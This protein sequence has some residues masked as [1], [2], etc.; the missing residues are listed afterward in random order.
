MINLVYGPAGCG[1]STYI[2]NRVIDD[3]R[4]RKK[5]FLIVPDQNIL[6]AEKAIVDSAFDVSVID[7]EVLSFRRLA[8]HVFRSLGG[9]SFNDIDEG[10]RLLIM[11][12]VLCETAPFLKTYNRIDEKNTSFAELM[13]STVNELKQFSITPAMLDNASVRL[14]ES[15]PTFSDKLHDISFIYGAYQAFLS[16]EYNDPADELTRLSETLDGS[17]FFKG[18]NVYFD[19]FDNYTPQQ[20]EVIHKIL[21]QA[22]NVTFSLCY[23]PDDTTGI[24]ATTQRSLRNLK[25]VADKLSLDIKE[26]HLKESK[27]SR[28]E[29]IEY[30]S[31]NLWRHEVPSEMYLGDRSHVDTIVC[32][33]SFEE[34]EAIVCDILKKV[35]NGVRY[36]DIL[37][38]ARDISAYEGIIDSEFENNGIPFFMSKRTDVTSKPIFK[39]ILAALAI[40]NKGWQFNDVISYVKTG[41]TGISRDECDILENY[42]SSW[43][44]KGSRWYDGI[45]WNMNPDGFS[46]KISDSGREMIVQAN[47]IRNKIV[48]PLMKFF[49]CIG[50]TTVL[51]VTRGLYDLLNDLKIREQIEE[52]AAKCRTEKRFVEEKEYV[53]LWNMLMNALDSAVEYAGEM[54]V[55]GDLYAVILGIILSKT[56]I[57]TIP[58]SVDQVMLGSASTLRTGSV[59][60]VYLLGVNEGIFPR[61]ADENCIFS[62]NEKN[63]LKTFDVE[64]SPGSDEQNCDELFWFYKAISC[65]QKGLILTYSDSDL[66]GSAKNLS[67]AGSRVNY[68]LNNKPIIRYSELSPEERLE[69]KSIALKLLALNRNN[70]LGLGLKKY[71]TKDESIKNIVEAFETP[72]DAVDSNINEDLAR[73]IYKGDIST[74]QSRIDTYVK[75]SFDYHCRYVL[76][77]QEKKSAVFRSNDIGNF[78]HAVL[79]R[80]MSRIATEDGIDTNIEDCEINRIVDEIINDYVRSV[81]VGLSENSPRF[82]QLVK[83]LK[84]TTLLL[85]RNLLAEFRQ[86]DFVPKFFEL[87]I[88]Y[89]NEEGVEPY[90]IPLSDGS[91]LYMR[92]VIDR[93][94]TYKKGK[95]VY[96]RIVDYK[97]GTKTFSPDDIE[98]GLNLQM[99]LYLFAIWNTKRDT[100]KEKIKCEGDIIPAGILYFAA[101]APEVNITNE[102][103]L[104]STYSIAEQKISRVGMLINDIEVLRAMDKELDHKYIPVKLYKNGNLSNTDYLK[105]VE[106][107]GELSRKIDDILSKIADEMKKGLVKAVPLEMKKSNDSPCTYCKM[108]PI[109]RRVTRGDND[110]F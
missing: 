94:D 95:D 84:R 42:A 34:C 45:D 66:R 82:I 50:G 109:C 58:A 36:K 33:D 105:T 49:D 12:R 64:L 30:V 101:K 55:N 19:S 18:C 5:S 1:K 24:F 77:L 67:V 103:E 15:N 99:L 38:I 75:C 14:K 81:C 62:D 97:T 43:N 11:W 2:Y 16:K 54:K 39:L 69:G 65:A 100:F 17:D 37:V 28:C 9:L 74:S 52:K 8:N 106:E 60:Y 108:K 92:G 91:K 41:L 93:V 63:I 86:S 102:E 68:L 89:D 72:L 29:D 25:K 80:F 48:P 104:E 85:I 22:D 70:E 61:S 44:I 88:S 79:E 51:D 96:I 57:G 23:D 40:K 90:V 83:R 35:R 4:N 32:H 46:E 31:R 53:Q 73:E 47:E 27:C 7:L 59:P 56:D 13:L 26:I 76:K 110:E 21:A 6:S 87:P 10:G 20:Y 78:V 71:L 107:F 98:K 3:L